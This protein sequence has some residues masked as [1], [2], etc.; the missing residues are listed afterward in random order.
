MPNT[1]EF[2]EGVFMPRGEMISVIDLR[3]CLG[4][5]PNKPD[6]KNGMF[7]ITRFSGIQMAFHIDEVLQI[8]KVYWENI[9]LPDSTATAGGA[10]LATGAVRIENRLT[11]ILDFER[12]VSAINP[13]SGVRVSDMEEYQPRNR[14]RSPILVVE[15]SKLLSKL[16]LDCLHRA[17]YTNVISAINGQEAWDKLCEFDRIGNVLD[18]VHC[19]ITDIEMP[20][21]DGHTLT[22]L[23]KESNSMRRI[24]VIIFSS[25][26]NDVIR[27]KGEKVGANAQLAKPDIGKLVT[28]VDGLVDEYESI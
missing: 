22:Q 17:G 25:I 10:D 19:I 8:H 28:L 2:I 13:E 1:H 14:S 6:V 7:F 26:I 15:D 18:R 20:Q 4:Y 12:I 21:M 24:P 27:K 9:F 16:I 23:V 11:V 3:R 5:E